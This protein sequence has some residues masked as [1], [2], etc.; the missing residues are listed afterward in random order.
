MTA[1]TA[2]TLHRLVTFPLSSS[3]WQQ[4]QQLS[5]CV[6]VPVVGP[7]WSASRSDLLVLQHTHTLARVEPES[8]V[9]LVLKAKLFM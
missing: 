4:Q 8:C 6:G 9:G 7:V 2:D 1:A 5:S 3:N